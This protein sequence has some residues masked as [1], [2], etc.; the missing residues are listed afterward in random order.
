MS[1]LQI[2]IQKFLP[3]LTAFSFDAGRMASLAVVIGLNAFGQV[4][5]IH[6]IR[7]VIVALVAGVDGIGV[8]MAGLTGNLTRITVVEGEGMAGE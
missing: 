3:D 6:F 8:N 5:F 1:G 7:I 4:Y 2:F